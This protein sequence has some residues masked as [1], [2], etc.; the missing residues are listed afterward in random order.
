MIKRP[1]SKW[2]KISVSVTA[3]LVG[4]IAAYAGY[5]YAASP[6]VIRQPTFEHYHFRMQIV[7]NGTLEDFGAEKYQTTYTKDLCTADLAKQPIHFHDNK[8][9]FGHIHWKG[10]TGGMV[11]KYYGWNYIGGLD[12]ALGYKLD[13]LAKIEKVT[14]HGINLPGQPQSTDFYIYSGDANAYSQRNFNDWKNKDLEDFFGTKS[15]VPAAEVSRSQQKNIFDSL[16]PNAYAHGTPNDAD[17]NDGTGS[18]PT[19]QSE[20]QAE[21][22]TRINNLIGN[23]VIFVQSSAP[24]EQQIKDRF[25]D[26][27]PLTESTCGG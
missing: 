5:A 23:V 12:Q 8:N 21:K 3:L 10:M 22:L 2:L 24:T 17:G 9:Q 1:T 4:I 11:M 14:T 16:F 19:S 6:A 15:N 7:V 25:N 27:Q 13:D 20:T 26:L 18:N